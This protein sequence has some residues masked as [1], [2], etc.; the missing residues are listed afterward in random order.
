VISFTVET[1]GGLANG[2]SLEE[3]IEAT[4]AET[5]SAAA[6]FVVNCA[7][8]SHFD[9]VLGGDNE[10]LQRIGG[11]RANASAKS[12][13]ELDESTELEIGDPQDLG[14]RYSSLTACYPSMRVL[15]GCCGTD[16]RHFA[17]ICEACMPRA[18]AEYMEVSCP[19]FH[20]HPL[21]PWRFRHLL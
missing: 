18:A 7:H 10:W 12:H 1:D 2:M 13:A 15:G 9:H 5:G 3:A 4:D 11:I 21:C 19:C 6:Y 14:R 17:A 16:H 8:S 20:C